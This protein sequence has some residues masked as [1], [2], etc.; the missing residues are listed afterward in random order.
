VLVGRVASDS[1]GITGCGFLHSSGG[2]RHAISLGDNPPLS[3]TA[4]DITLS[5]TPIEE[6][7]DEVFRVA[8]GDDILPRGNEGWNG[9]QIGG[10]MPT[11]FTGLDLTDIASNETGLIY[12][13]EIVQAIRELEAPID[14]AGAAKDGRVVVVP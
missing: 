10:G 13:N 9:G 14:E 3:T 2:V 11:G 8:F 5:G 12:R 7:L 6:R 4:V 1:R